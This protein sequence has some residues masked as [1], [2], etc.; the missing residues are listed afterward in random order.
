[1]PELSERTKNLGT[2]NAFVVTQEVSDLQSK[3]RNIIS[4]CI[5][6]PDFDTPSYIKKGAIIGAQALLLPGIVI[7]EES[8]VA[9]GA[10]VTKDVPDRKVVM[11]VPAK[12]AYSRKEYDAKQA[13]WNKKNH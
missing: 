13:K 8:I 6:Q 5:G 12:I 3:G 11:G 2:E 7:G 1:M 4:F 9:G 10:V